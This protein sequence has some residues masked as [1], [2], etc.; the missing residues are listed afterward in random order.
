MMYYK[1]S[2]VGCSYQKC[3]KQDSY[4]YSIACAFD[5]S[6]RK[7]EAIYEASK[8]GGC[9]PSSCQTVYSDATCLASGLCGRPDPMPTTAST[10]TTPA[11][12]PTTTTSASLSTTTNSASTTTTSASL[13]TTTD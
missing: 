9:T 11:S 5:Q 6:I 8:S 4:L 3:E 10:T 13:P 1:S 7:G 2:L 12:L